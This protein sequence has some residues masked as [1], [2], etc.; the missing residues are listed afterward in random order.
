MADTCLLI[1]ISIYVI[2]YATR[3]VYF[4]YS[5]LASNVTNYKRLTDETIV[6]TCA[7]SSG[8]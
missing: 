4:Y 8:G 2:L 3:S 6:R 5:G 7:F 1:N